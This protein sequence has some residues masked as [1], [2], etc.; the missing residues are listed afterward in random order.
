MLA[1]IHELTDVIQKLFRLG[2]CES[3]IVK[4]FFF[5]IRVTHLTAGSLITFVLTDTQLL[6]H[7]FFMF[8]FLNLGLITIQRRANFPSYGNSQLLAI[9]VARSFHLTF[10]VACNHIRL[11]CL[12]LAS[13][14]LLVPV[15]G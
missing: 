2:F 15:C 12:Q 9:D 4:M 5:Q 11:D 13:D 7:R 8:G 14:S 3:L 6:D 1:F 10:Y